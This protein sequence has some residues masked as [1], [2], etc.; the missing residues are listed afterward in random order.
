MTVDNALRRRSGVCASCRGVPL[1]SG[2]LKKV[3][4]VFNAKIKARADANLRELLRGL[5]AFLMTGIIE[6]VD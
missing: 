3:E 6:F 4:K 1:S 2:T 5:K